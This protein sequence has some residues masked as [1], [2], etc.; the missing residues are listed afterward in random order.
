MTNL[1]EP[2]LCPSE[3]EVLAVLKRHPKTGLTR[4]ELE[5]MCR[6]RSGSICARVRDLFDK[7]LIEPNGTRFDP[8]TK[9]HVEVVRVVQ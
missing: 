2:K 7:K 4:R 9:K 8:L 1:S 6:R 5:V 3:S